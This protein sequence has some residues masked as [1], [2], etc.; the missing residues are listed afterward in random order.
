MSFTR[1]EE[2]G[3]EFYTLK[4]NGLSGMSISGLARLCDVDRRAISRLLKRIHGTKIRSEWLKPFLG[5]NLWLGLSSVSGAKIIHGE[6]CVAIIGYYAFEARN[7]TKAAEYAFKKF[8]Y[9]GLESWIQ[10]ITGWKAQLEAPEP[11]FEAVEKFINDGLR[12]TARSSAQNRHFSSSNS[13][14][15]N[16]Q[17]AEGKQFQR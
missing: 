8:A 9:M 11:T 12:P 14:R 1:V 2:D 15:R 16:S 13:P 4:D 3:V 5:K 6:V 7:K 17:N 10:K